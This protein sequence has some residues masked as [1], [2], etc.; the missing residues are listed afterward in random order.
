MQI[1]VS[2][3]EL[4]LLLTWK[5]LSPRAG[6]IYHL[7]KDYE[8]AELLYSHALKMNPGLAV[9][10]DNLSKLLKSKRKTTMTSSD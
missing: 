2:T 4:N 7:M 3:V 1:L 9:A 6:V 10:Q 8:K 5:L